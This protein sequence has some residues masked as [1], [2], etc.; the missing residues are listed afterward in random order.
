MIGS[1]N[2]E[3]CESKPNLSSSTNASPVACTD[4]SDDGFDKITHE[5]VQEVAEELAI[6]SINT[7]YKSL[8]L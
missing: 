3:V 7:K 8:H 5:D 2:I 6:P 1:A 4:S